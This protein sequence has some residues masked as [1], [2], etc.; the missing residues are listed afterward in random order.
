MSFFK[1]ILQNKKENKNLGKKTKGKNAFSNALSNKSSKWPSR[2][3]ANRLEPFCEPVLNP[4]HTIKRSDEIFTIGSCFARNIEI[5]LKKQNFSVPSGDVK[6]PQEELWPGT[7]LHSGLLNK[8]TPQAI[9]NEL[10]YIFNDSY[11]A[12][13]FLIEGNNKKFVDMQLHSNQGTTFE[14]GIERRQQIK[15]MVKNFVTTADM[16]VVT[17]GLVEVWWDSVNEVYLN[18]MPSKALIDKYENRFFFETMS[19]DQVF[20]SVSNIIKLLKTHMKENAWV[21]LTVSPVPL[22]RTFRDKD[23]ITANMYSK[24][25]LRV[26]AELESEKSDF[27]EYFPSYE[28]VMLSNRGD[29][30]QDD[31]IHVE[32]S[33]IAKITNRMIKTYCKVD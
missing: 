15:S 28:S 31:Q 29:T 23:V 5:A 20:E 21:M 25:L 24:S 4:E 11:K 32:S 33:A 12:E 10:E 17:L 7:G 3:T 16:I 30:W 6:F 8:Y 22:A 13:D 18:E 1:K 9:L 27:V 26:A 2:S 19:P 14:R